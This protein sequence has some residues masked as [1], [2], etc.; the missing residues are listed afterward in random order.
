MYQD[1]QTPIGYTPFTLSTQEAEAEESKF[2]A[3]L[4]YKIQEF[5]DG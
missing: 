3:S 1:F 5:Q 2:E 4:V